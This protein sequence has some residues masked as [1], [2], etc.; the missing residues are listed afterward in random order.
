MDS[1]T[2]NGQAKHAAVMSVFFA[3]DDTSEDNE[4]LKQLKVDEPNNQAVDGFD[5]NKFMNSVSVSNYYV[6][7]GSLTEPP[8]TEGIKWII[9]KNHLNISDVQAKAFK[10]IWTDR[11]KNS[12]TSHTSQCDKRFQNGAYKFRNGNAR[13]TQDLNGRVINKSLNYFESTATMLSTAAAFT[14]ASLLALNSF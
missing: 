6:Y 7:D 12:F 13:Q 14:T 2:G 4:F 11:N 9:L 8:C 1:T 10:K 5:L 3:E